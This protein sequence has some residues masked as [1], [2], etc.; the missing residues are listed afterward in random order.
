MRG[1]EHGVVRTAAI[2]GEVGDG[3]GFVLRRRC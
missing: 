1:M 3:V 2:D